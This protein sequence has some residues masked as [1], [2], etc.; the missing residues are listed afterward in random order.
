PDRLR[1]PL[2]KRDGEWHEATWDEAFAEIERRLLPIVEEHGRDAVA[3]YL[4]NPSVHNH[5]STLY[6]RPLVMALGTTNIFSAS[7]LDQMP[8][9]VSAGLMFG[10]TLTIPV[11]DLDRTAYLL[12]LGANPYHSNGS[13]CTAPDFPGRL[14]AIQARGGRVV[15][16]DPRRTR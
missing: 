9:H 5:A 3:L 11:P 14:E 16:G 13:L 1:A 12:M 6:V 4:G 2:V 7:T 8:K 15:V 10:D